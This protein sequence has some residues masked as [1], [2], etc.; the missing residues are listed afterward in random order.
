MLSQYFSLLGISRKGADDLLLSSPPLVL[1]EVNILVVK[2]HSQPQS[3]N[4][5]L[6]AQIPASQLKCQLQ[7]SNPTL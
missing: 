6:K 2:L 3:S 7:G 5:S 4:P 1:F